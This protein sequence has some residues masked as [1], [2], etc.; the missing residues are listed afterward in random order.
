MIL[1]F[2]SLQ[3]LQAD[4]ALFATRMCRWDDERRRRLA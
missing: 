1:P 3:N 4:T 2:L